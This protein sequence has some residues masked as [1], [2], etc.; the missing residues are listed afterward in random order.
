M[1]ARFGQPVQP[2][3][4]LLLDPFPDRTALR[5]TKDRAGGAGRRRHLSGLRSESPLPTE[6]P[7]RTQCG[8][9]ASAPPAPC[10]DCDRRSSS[11]PDPIGNQI[12]QYQE[13]KTGPAYRR[14]GGVAVGRTAEGPVRSARSARSVRAASLLLCW[15]LFSFLTVILMPMDAAR[16][17]PR[18]HEPVLA[19]PAHAKTAG[20][21]GCRNRIIKYTH[22]IFPQ[23]FSPFFKF[24]FFKFL[25]FIGCHQ[26]MI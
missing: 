5:D 9:T 7:L 15:F 16:R 20:Q 2:G 4:P 24:Y 19:W 18:F 21:A 14:D 10:Q 12:S 3:Q 17:L 22:L 23:L 8:Q 6:E 25:S 26:D 13:E 11:E 1:R